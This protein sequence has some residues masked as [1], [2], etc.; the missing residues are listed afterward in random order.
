LVLPGLDAPLADGLEVQIHRAKPVEVHVDGRVLRTRTQ[1]SS[2]GE[3]LGE[4]GVWLVGQDFCDPALAAPLSDGAQLRVIRVTER[5]EVEQEE[6][7]FETVW[8]PD[9]TLE[10]DALYLDDPGAIGIRR[11]RY[12]VVYHDQAPVERVLEDDWLAQAPRQRQIAYGTKVVVRTLDTPDGE[13]EYWRRIRVFRTAY[14]ADT[15]GKT[16]DHPEYGVTR[17]GWKMRHGIIATDPRV[18]RLRT[19]L[20]VPGYGPGIAGDT[21]GLIVGRHIDLGYE[22]DSLVWH[23]EWGYVY[24]LTPV[25]PAREIPYILPDFPTGVYR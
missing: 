20:Y 12:K 2:V 1:S 11:R 21:G 25:P 9:D 5:T 15:C 16:R 22:V 8:V 10:L 24:L 7:P 6:L 18:I 23:H 3:V 19:P 4:L 17:L 13:I 14:T